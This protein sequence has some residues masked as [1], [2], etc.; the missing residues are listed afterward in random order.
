MLARIGSSRTPTIVFGDLNAGPHSAELQPLL[1]RLHDTWP[2][3][4]GPGFTYPATAP[5]K[6]IDYVLTSPD[7]SVAHAEVLATDASDHRP[8]IVD[9]RMN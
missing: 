3:S 7:F 1:A 4:A 8:L 6:R 5:A 9:L 2:A